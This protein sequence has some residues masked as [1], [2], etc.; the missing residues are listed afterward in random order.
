VTDGG[1]C[2]L[3]ANTIIIDTGARPASPTIPGLATV[4][5][6][7]SSSILELDILPDHLLVLGGGYIGVEFSQM[8]RRFG[9]KVTIVQSGRQLLAR[10]DP[11]VAEAV[12][13]ILREDG[14][15]VLLQAMT[16]QVTA[17]ANGQVQL[18]VGMPGAADRTLIGSHLLV[19]TGR[20]P[21]TEQLNLRL[22]GIETDSRGAIRVNERLETA[23]PGVYALG[24]VKGGPAFTHVAFDDARI[25][26][27]NLL[28]GGNVT[29][30]GRLVPYT[31]FIDPQLGRVGLTETEARDQ[32]RAIRVA[33]LPMAKVLRAMDLGETRGVMK[34]IVDAK[35]NQILGAA[36]FGVE[37]GEVMTVVHVAMMGKLPYTALRDGVICHPTLAEGLTKL[38]AAVD[39]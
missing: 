10:E 36:I 13:N 11:D 6:L 25:L 29:T 15:D 35:T 24:D 38:F 8:F 30:I 5:A 16:R 39:E 21:N 19:A 2:H 28:K 18:A 20:V 1:T 33:T 31:I 12:T 37:G 32:G 34:A 17:A 4:A 14:I 7:D 9:A 26:R 22:A 3:S 27:T 23:V